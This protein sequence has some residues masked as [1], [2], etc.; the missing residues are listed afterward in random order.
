MS[1]R[2]GLIPVLVVIAGC[3]WLVFCDWLRHRSGQ[4]NRSAAIVIG[5]TYLKAIGAVGL[6]VCVIVSIALLVGGSRGKEPQ[7]AVLVY[8]KLA[9]DGFGTW[10]D[11]DQIAAL[12]DGLEAALRAVRVG[13]FD[14]DEFGQGYCTLF[15]YGANADRLFDAIVQPLHEFSARAGSY[16]IRRYGEP[17]AREER[18]E[19]TY[20]QEAE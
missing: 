18:S 8:L 4:R 2:R 17:G 15:L 16:V 7:H 6:A 12:E 20:T 13:E 19:L 9:N 1:I 5:T 10:Q 11:I 3:A 14:G